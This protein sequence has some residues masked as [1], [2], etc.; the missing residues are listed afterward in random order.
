MRRREFTLYGGA[1]IAL[2]AV[3]RA[4]S[5]KLPTLGFLGTGTPQTQGTWLAALVQRLHELNWIDGH[6]IAIDVHW[7]EGRPERYAERAVAEHSIYIENHSL[8]P[9]SRLRRRW[10]S[11]CANGRAWKS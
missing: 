4:Q 10:P 8:L 2:P 6:T 1:A 7:A 3:A 11:G 5:G 9:L